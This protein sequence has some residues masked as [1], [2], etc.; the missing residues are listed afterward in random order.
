M[1]LPG[2]RARTAATLVLVLGTMLA[3]RAHA[4]QPA[5]VEPRVDNLDELLRGCAARRAEVLQ[6][7]RAIDAWVA[8]QEMLGEDV[9]GEFA[10]QLEPACA[11]ET[12]GAWVTSREPGVW[13]MT[14]PGEEDLLFATV[15]LPVPGL[16]VSSDRGRSWHYRHLFLAGYNVDH[17][18]LLRGVAYRHGLLAV[19]TGRGL[20][21]SHDQGA[22]FA[23]VLEGLPIT[24]VA[25][26]PLD[27][28]G[29]VAGGDG[30]SFLST[31][32]GVTWTDL[33][34]TQFTRAL[35]TR[36][37]YLTSHVTSIEFDPRN[38]NIV[39]VGTGSHLYRFVMPGSGGGPG[40]WQ[41][42]EGDRLGR[43]HDDSTVYNVA[44]GS[45]FMI[46]T[47]NGVYILSRLGADLDR[48]QAD[49]SWQK[50]RD[51]SFSNRGV[52]GPRGNL[53][54]YFVAEDPTDAGRILVA[55]F[56]GLYEGRSA[57]GKMRW[58]RIEDLPYYSPDA[59]Y[60]EYTSITWTGA[61]EAVVGS[62]YRGIFFQPRGP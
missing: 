52:G 27:G 59:G 11:A 60:P 7:N 21:L 15:N 42:M 32:G 40:R 48:A 14:S 37:R 45:R 46:S 38:Q 9:R 62:R 39:Y 20:L 10:K 18:F 43:V 44:I 13:A 41:A 19:A 49:V 29:I 61:G 50:F 16:M 33:G 54:S 56:A 57:G 2:P 28:R 31:D 30:T 22:T 23:A 58:K 47:C 25:I 6:H 26:S 4:W 51:A 53:R 34:F 36:N 55:D 24:A 1:I 35:S 5:R 3:A 8:Y 12:I 17:G